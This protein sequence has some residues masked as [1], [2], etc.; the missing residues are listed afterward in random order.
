MNMKH[1]DEVDHLV[2]SIR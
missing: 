2:S 1:T